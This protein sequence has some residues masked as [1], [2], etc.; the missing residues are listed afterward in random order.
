M[1]FMSGNYLP[2][3]CAK[4]SPGITYF[5]ALLFI[6]CHHVTADWGIQHSPIRGD[7]TRKGPI[8][9]TADVDTDPVQRDPCR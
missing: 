5:A 9:C 7:Q 2:F 4:Y 6:F 8:N 1:S 3:S